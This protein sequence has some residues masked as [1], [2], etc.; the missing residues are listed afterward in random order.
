MHASV[1]LWFL[2]LQYHQS[3]V[4]NARVAE[5]NFERPIAI[6]LD[7]KGPEIRTGVLRDGLKEAS[8]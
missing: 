1:N 7:T 2:C 4:D 8:L 5:K 3:V 6:A